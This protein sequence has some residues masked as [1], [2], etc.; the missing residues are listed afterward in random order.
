MRDEFW[1]PAP[2]LPMARRVA[3]S[4]AY[5]DLLVDACHALDVPD[6]LSGLPP[7]TE[8]D[9]ERLRVEHELEEAGLRLS[10]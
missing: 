3:L 5:D 8:R 1:S 7:G 4:R 6:S 10:A 2:G 9:A